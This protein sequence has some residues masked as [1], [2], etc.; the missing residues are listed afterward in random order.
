MALVSLSDLPCQADLDSA[1]LLQYTHLTM[2]LLFLPGR[3]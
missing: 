2:P 1:L 3:D